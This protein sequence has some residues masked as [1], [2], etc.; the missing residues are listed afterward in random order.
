MGCVFG[1]FLR[2]GNIFKIIIIL[3]NACGVFIG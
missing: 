2:A 1:W 3:P